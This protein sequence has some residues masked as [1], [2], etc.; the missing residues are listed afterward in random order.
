MLTIALAT[1]R[2]RDASFTGSFAA[3]LVGVA[4]LSSVSIALT[5]AADPGGHTPLRFA[6]APAVLTP[7][8]SFP[9]RSDGYTDQ[10][11]LAG[12]PA[13]PAAALSVARASGRVV[14]DRSFY[15]QLAGSRLPNG[16]PP[17]GHGWSAAAFTPYRLLA[18]TPPSAPDQVVLAGAPRS[19]LGQQVSVLTAA[20]PASYRVSGLTAA[21]SFE[22]AVFFSD[23]RAAELSPPVNAA[24]VYGSASELRQSIAALNRSR[25]DSLPDLVL[26]GNAR[27]D[28]DPTRADER[29]ALLSVTGLLGVTGGLAAIVSIFLVGATFAF[30]VNQRQRELALLRLAGGTPQQ[31]RTMVLAEAT[32][33]G[34]AA[35]ALGSLIGLAGGPLLARW[36]VAR[37]AAPQWF[38]IQLS[39]LV[40]ATVAGVL[41]AGV[42]VAVIGAALAC[43]R[44]GQI[45][46]IEA[47]RQSQVSRSGMG[48]ARWLLGL[49]MLVVD[50]ALLW[51]VPLADPLVAIGLNQAFA[52]VLVVAV[53]LLAPLAIRPVARL[54]TLPLVISRG[55]SGLLIRQST[56]AAVRRA[57]ATAVPVIIT[58]GLAAA[59]LGSLATLNAAKSH[60][61][62]R[63]LS[64]QFT[65]LSRKNPGLDQS[66]VARVAALP[67]VISE[68]VRPVQLYGPQRGSTSPVQYQ[69][70]AVQPAAL[71]KLFNLQVVAGSIAGL[72]DNTVLI[73]QEWGKKVG[74]K[75]L[76][77][78]GD[79]TRSQLTV[80]AVLRT[81]FGGN[82]AF[83]TPSHA[84]GVLA[85]RIDVR[86][87]AG[88]TA[89][90]IASAIDRADVT[91]L[92]TADWSGAIDR[93]QVTHS[94]EN[95]TT[96]LIIVLLYSGLATANTI[97]MATSARGRE[98]AALRL[99]GTGKRQI[100]LISTAESLI[101]VLVG[102]LLAAAA[103]AISMVGLKAA[104]RDV[105]DSSRIVI[106]WPTLAGLTAVIATVA[107]LAT[108][109]PALLVMR[110]RPIQLVG[111]RE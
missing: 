110:A 75:V 24:V 76:V 5:G 84:S 61:L 94:R 16:R 77:I 90:A 107:V 42:C 87:P 51:L 10:L 47:L 6:A 68:A 106:E 72:A 43:L 111:S 30:S 11:S 14:E 89:A 12:R 59:L 58:L 20:G 104:I 57:A 33:I 74:D 34:L 62:D 13:L 45:R 83:V 91:V 23:A 99:A 71:T 105:T 56:F 3:L 41:I 29:L 1:L 46:P 44:A 97:A 64:S 2:S 27:H 53:A 28:A 37:Q 79:G 18:G 52:V 93:R 31:I 4:L 55:A 17:L 103:T 102:A 40:L 26:T 96:V 70:Q 50:V 25:P 7:A 82:S 65:V 80:A 78:F 48:V 108:V 54:A 73:D 67:G 95:A 38:R 92:A 69:A 100:V 86:G 49:L 21:T 81:G 35:S 66:V 8:S 60:E 9:I 36:L 88:L 39:P 19:M 32:L 98:F 109:I 85:D 15:A 22:Q 63:S 101:A